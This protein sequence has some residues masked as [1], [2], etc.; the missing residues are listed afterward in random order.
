MAGESQLLPD[1]PDPQVIRARL[2]VLV[3]ETAVLKK[4]LSVSERAARERERLRAF[5]DRETA[6]VR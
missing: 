6:D 2:A 4:Q 3:S 5:A 1:V